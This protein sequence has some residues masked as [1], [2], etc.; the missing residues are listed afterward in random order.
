MVRDSTETNF[1]SLLPTQKENKFLKILFKSIV[2]SYNL[3]TQEAKTWGQDKASLP[4]RVRPYLMKQIQNKQH[5]YG[6]KEKK[7]LK[8][9]LKYY[10]A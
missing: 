5:Q 6:W 3:S 10:W 9:I 1:L 8:S 2:Q 4:S 7:H